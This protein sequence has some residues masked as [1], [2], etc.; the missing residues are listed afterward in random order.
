MI[1]QKYSVL[2]V[3]CASLLALSGA[4]RAD[5]VDILSG[6]GPMRLQ[7]SPNGEV[8]GAY[9]KLKGVMH[10]RISADGDSQ[11]SSSGGW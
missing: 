3:A 7:I 9:P 11:A 10:G 1:R 5:V 6:D 4:A 2:G 8:D